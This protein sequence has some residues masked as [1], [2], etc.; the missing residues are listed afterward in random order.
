M[1]AKTV[2]RVGIL[3]CGLPMTGHVMAEEEPPPDAPAAPDVT[4]PETPHAPNGN[5]CPS[6]FDGVCDEP[7]NCPPGTDEDDCTGI[8]MP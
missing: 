3:L 4:V 8:P 2:I 7:L 6:A 1:N 5:F